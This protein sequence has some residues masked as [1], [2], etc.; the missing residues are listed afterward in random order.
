ME[1]FMEIITDNM[2]MM[3]TYNFGWVKGFAKMATSK[4]RSEY[5]Y[6]LSLKSYGLEG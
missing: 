1:R 2:D 3:N 5:V 6:Y 4:I